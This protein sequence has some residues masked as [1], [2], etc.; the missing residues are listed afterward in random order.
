MES[1]ISAADRPGWIYIFCEGNGVFKVGRTENLERRM[2]EWDRDCP[3]TAKIW[4]GAFWSSLAHITGT[5]LFLNT[6]FILS[7]VA[8]KLVHLQLELQCDIRPRYRCSC[9]FLIIIIIRSYR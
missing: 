1:P 7:I 3:G 9:E 5:F 6:R 4:L 8:E 2:R